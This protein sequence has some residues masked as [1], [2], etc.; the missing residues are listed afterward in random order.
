M[1]KLLPLVKNLKFSV[2]IAI[3]IFLQGCVTAAVVTVG[4]GV[5]MATD[6]RSVGH[7]IDDQT[8]ELNAYTKLSE[9]P[10]IKDQTNIQ[11]VAMNG[12]VLVVGQAPTVFLRDAVMKVINSIDGISKV[13]NQIRIGNTTSILTKSHDTW[14]TSKVK[15]ALLSDNSIDGTN[16]KV[17][18]E[19]SE[20]FLMGLVTLKEANKAVNIARNISGVTKVL[21]AFEYRK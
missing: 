1:N 2:L 11:V 15:V 10:A 4:T 18:T 21:K 12:V 5:K 8:I 19:N 16:I 14:L 6:R 17:V 7:Q 3:V 9:N 20:V 13:Y